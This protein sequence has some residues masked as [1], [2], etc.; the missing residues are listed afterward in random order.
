LGTTGMT[1]RRPRSTGVL[2]SAGTLQ[3]AKDGGRCAAMSTV[4]TG[5]GVA[6]A[7]QFTIPARRLASKD[8]RFNSPPPPSKLLDC[9]MLGYRK[10]S[11]AMPTLNNLLTASPKGLNPQPST[12]A[13]KGVV[14][15]AGRLASGLLL[16]RPGWLG[17][18]AC[19]YSGGPC[20]MQP[21]L[22]SAF[23]SLSIT[24]IT[25]C[26]CDCY[27]HV[28]CRLTTVRRMAIANTD[29]RC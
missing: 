27:G 14:R 4:D 15:S 9:N 19:G 20:C 26:D 1:R 8:P 21:A 10:P 13:S 28:S 16:T 5:C 6:V 3:G 29:D 2:T 12:R 24:A 25:Y 22:A 17:S 7:L 18:L 23:S 11:S